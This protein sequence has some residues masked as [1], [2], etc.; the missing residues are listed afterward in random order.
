LCFHRS[1]ERQGI[2]NARWPYGRHG[3]RAFYSADDRHTCIRRPAVERRQLYCQRRSH[4]SGPPTVNR[5]K[6]DQKHTGH[7]NGQQVSLNL[8]SSMYNRICVILQEPPLII[9]NTRKSLCCVFGVEC[10]SSLSIGHCN[11]N[12]WNLNSMKTLYLVF[13]F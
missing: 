2:H 9:K 8:I 6:T 13:K 1:Q 10:T 4:R 12:V 5:S 11:I 7:R 3:S